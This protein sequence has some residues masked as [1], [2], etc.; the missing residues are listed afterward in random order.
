MS[1]ATGPGNL[2]VPPPFKGRWS[3]TGGRKDAGKGLGEYGVLSLLHKFPCHK[4]CPENT[5]ARWNLVM[6]G[7]ARLQPWKKKL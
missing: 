6:V 3:R 1:K 4:F 5:L 2:G 7:N